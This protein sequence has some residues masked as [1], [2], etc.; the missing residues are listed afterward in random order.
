MCATV[1]LY[2]TQMFKRTPRENYCVSEQIIFIKE[3]LFSIIISV[4]VLESD[5][6]LFSCFGI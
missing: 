4:F 3:K 6:D 5:R 2:T 1:L